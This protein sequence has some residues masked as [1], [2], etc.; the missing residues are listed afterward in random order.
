MGE[1]VDVQ[2]KIIESIVSALEPKQIDAN[3]LHMKIANKLAELSRSTDERRR[4][5]YTALS[6]QVADI[7]LSG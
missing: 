5:I 4:L 2:K 6:L 3:R 7:G 1:F